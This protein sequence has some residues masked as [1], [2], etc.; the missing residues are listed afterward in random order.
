MAS[1]S[2]IPNTP[3]TLNSHTSVDLKPA[4]PLK[5]YLSFSSSK[6]R[7]PCLF[8]VRASDADF[9]AAVVAGNVPDA[10]PVPPTPAAPAGT[11]VVTSLVSIIAK[12]ICVC[13]FLVQC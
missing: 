11:P 10:P 6:R 4:L 9:E 5:N 7:P 12:L 2:T 1:S 13:A 8:T 3:L